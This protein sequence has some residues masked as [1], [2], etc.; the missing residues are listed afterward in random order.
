MSCSSFQFSLVAEKW[1]L[2][3]WFKSSLICL[4]FVTRKI[5]RWKFGDK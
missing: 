5:E 4:G 2:N 3:A 1:G